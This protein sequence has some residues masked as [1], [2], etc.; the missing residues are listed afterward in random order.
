[1]N[2]L[3]FSFTVMSES[4]EEDVGETTSTPR[5][6]RGCSSTHFTFPSHLSLIKGIN[7]VSCAPLSLQETLFCAFCHL[8]SMSISFSLIDWIHLDGVAS[9]PDSICPSICVNLM[10]TRLVNSSRLDCRQHTRVNLLWI[11]PFAHSSHW[12]THS[13]IILHFFSTCKIMTS[14]SKGCH[15]HAAAVTPAGRVCSQ[16]STREHLG[17]CL[18][19]RSLFIYLNWSSHECRADTCHRCWITSAFTC[20]KIIG[21][22]INCKR[23]EYL[24]IHSRW[25]HLF[26]CMNIYWKLCTYRILWE[27]SHYL[28]VSGSERICPGVKKGRR[29]AWKHAAKTAWERNLPRVCLW[30]ECTMLVDDT[31]ET[32]VC[33]SSWHGEGKPSPTM[34]KLQHSCKSEIF[35]YIACTGGCVRLAREQ[36]TST[37]L[38][39]RGVWSAE[40]SAAVF[41]HYIRWLSSMEAANV[42]NLTCLN[43]QNAERNSIGINGLFHRDSIALIVCVTVPSETRLHVFL[44]VL[45]CVCITAPFQLYSFFKSIV[46]AVRW[47]WIHRWYIIEELNCRGEQ[48]I[49]PSRYLTLCSGTPESKMPLVPHRPHQQRRLWRILISDPVLSQ[50]WAWTPWRRRQ[51]GGWF[52]YLR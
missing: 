46:G 13:S 9:T 31:C 52:I 6:R 51:E 28:W 41:C 16:V 15:Q 47:R 27:R 50:G 3:A 14:G 20:Q 39:S 26:L 48:Y 19:H 10:W 40:K 2:A 44:W 18:I 34:H 1:M 36:S 11:T 22:W 30:C 5:E 12:M 25:Q 29:E 8:M 49:S 7:I 23:F 38:N 4:C 21:I 42:L 32:E 43:S 35:E 45:L 33:F 17:S 24:F 37:H